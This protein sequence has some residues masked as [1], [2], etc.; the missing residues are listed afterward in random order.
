VTVNTHIF[1]WPKQLDKIISLSRISLIYNQKKSTEQNIEWKS[2]EDKMNWEQDKSPLGQKDPHN[3]IIIQ[4]YC[5]FFILMVIL[6]LSLR[7]K[8]T[9]LIKV[10]W[11][12]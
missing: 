9:L 4:S 1:F 3:V 5:I 6:K 12:N 2:L 10:K 7:S 11:G 8:L